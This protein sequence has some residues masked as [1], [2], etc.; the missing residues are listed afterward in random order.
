MQ[1]NEREAFEEWARKNDYPI[2]DGGFT[3]PHYASAGTECAFE[4]FQAGRE[5]ER[6]QATKPLPDDEAAVDALK[7]EFKQKVEELAK[8]WV[9]VLKPIGDKCFHDHNGNCQAHFVSN[10]CEAAVFDDLISKHLGE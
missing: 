5:Y 1:N 9:A 10:P 4:G 2:E 7:A 8:A 3:N 6:T